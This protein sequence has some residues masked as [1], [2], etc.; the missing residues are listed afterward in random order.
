MSFEKVQFAFDGKCYVVRANNHDNDGQQS[1]G[2]GKTSFVDVISIAL[3]GSSLTGRNVKDC[4]NWNNE[5]NKYFTVTLYMENLLHKMN[6]LIERK[7]YS[8]S[9]GQELAILVNEAVPKT[10]PS[11]N[12]VVNGVD[13]RAGNTYIL[14]EILDISEED[15]LNYFLISKKKYK[16][17][18][19]VNTDIKLEVIGRFSRADMVDR[20]ITKLE[21]N[22]S[23]VEFET[24][25]ERK[26]LAHYEGY[27][28]ALKGSLTEAAEVNFENE[29]LLKVN[30]YKAQIDSIEGKILLLETEVLENEKLIAKVKSEYEDVNTDFLIEQQPL[31]VQTQGDLEY[32]QQEQRDINVKIV[33]IT[34]YLAGL[35]TCPACEHQFSLKATVNYTESDLKEHQD[36]LKEIEACIINEQTFLKQALLDV[37]EV[38]KTERRNKERE[39]VEKNHNRT[40]EN[41]KQNQERLLN[42]ISDI[43]KQINTTV[44]KTY[45]DE[46]SN[47]QLQID[48]KENELQEIRLRIEGLSGE[49]AN[50]KN[51][52]DHFYDFKFYLGNKPIENICALV[53]QYLK[54]NGSDLNL[55][56]EGFKKL[57]SGEIRQALTPVI[58]RN[59]QNPQNFQQFSEGE[60]ARLNLTVDLAFQQ[61]INSASKYGGL[62]F[63]MNDELLNPLDSLGVGNAAT[64]FNQLNKTILLVSHSGSDLVYENTIVIE[65]KN[66]I[67]QLT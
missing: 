43:E 40:I 1:N 57:R 53:N 10:L 34:N 35:I 51:W 42:E 14:E 38:F 6:C 25:G 21:E 30:Q 23:D 44:A 18:L 45:A 17:F 8:S 54:L 55:F 48:D 33:K 26:S 31:I 62:D 50:I 65:K 60:R 13:V 9:K 28:E 49:V 56:I 39:V 47:I 61:L 67:S 32:L 15:L 3:F 24:E 29:K 2:G 27:V 59:W 7:I 41:I 63:Y 12:G 19:E 64:A 52:I 4:V 37:E 36:K 22:I 46:C 20:V 16:P 66:K 5:V 11:K 58:Y